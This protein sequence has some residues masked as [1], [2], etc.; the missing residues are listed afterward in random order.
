MARPSFRRLPRALAIAPGLIAAWS[1]AAFV[2]ARIVGIEG[3]EGT[4][5]VATAF[6]RSLTI[7]VTVGLVGAWLETGPLARAGRVLPLWAALAVR[8]LAYALAVTLGI[9][10][11]IG[12][13]AWF[14]LGVAPRVLLRDPQFLAFLQGSGIW[15]VLGLLTLASF[16]I[17]LGLQLR[18][19]LGPEVLRALFLGRYR[20]PVHEE[21]VF[22]FLDLTD[23]TAIAERLGPLAFTDFKNDFFADVA[24]PV[25]ATGGRIVQYVGDE[26][27]VAWPMKA[28]V[29][30]GAP[31]RFFALVDAQIARR[32]ER[33]RQRHGVVPAFKAGC[34]GGPVVTAEVGDLKRDIVHSG[35]VVNTAARIEAECRPR[36]RRLLVSQALAEAMPLPDGL[37][38]EPLGPVGLRGKAAEVHICAVESIGPDATPEEAPSPEAPA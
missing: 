16:V 6:T 12:S 33:Y 34:H 3:P 25:L 36:G 4:E 30:S 21:R 23:S 32:A 10:T 24:E 13:V 29:A 27:M 17:N 28:A 11:I 9:L 7:G 31:L 2:T 37:A 38:L 22:L 20:Q 8:T 15:A 14:R 5:P 1:V 19:V 35:D 18:R 26:V